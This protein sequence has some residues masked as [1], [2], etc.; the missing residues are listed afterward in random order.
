M[1]FAGPRHAQMAE[2]FQREREILATLTHQNIARLYD[3]GVSGSGHAYLAMEYVNGMP[4]THYC[5]AARLS[6]RER[7]QIF[8]QVLEAVEFAHAQLVL[9]RDLK[10]SNI[11]VTQQG[12]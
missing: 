11:L 8:L 2:R 10:P 5:D 7:L 12:R 9:H 4:L 6:I 3:A 1:P